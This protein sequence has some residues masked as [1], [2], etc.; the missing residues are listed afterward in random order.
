MQRPLRSGRCGSEE[1]GDDPRCVPL[2]AWIHAVF[3]HQ[4]HA[5]CPSEVAHRDQSPLFP[6][7]AISWKTH[8]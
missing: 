1:A 3:K 6:L 2:G 5:M 4:P 7:S 8:F